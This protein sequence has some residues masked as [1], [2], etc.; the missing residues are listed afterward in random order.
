MSGIAGCRAIGATVQSRWYRGE[1]RPRIWNVPRSLMYP[2]IPASPDFPE[3]ERGILAF[4]KGDDT[5]Q[6]SIDNRDGCPSGCSTTA[7]RSPTACRTTA[8]C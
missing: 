6:A 2:S 3:I 8:T 4:W 7:R 5:F 1:S